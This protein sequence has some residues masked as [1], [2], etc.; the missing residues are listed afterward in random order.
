MHSWGETSAGRDP[1][2]YNGGLGLTGSFIFRGLDITACAPVLTRVRIELRR[3]PITYIMR[4]TGRPINEL[5]VG[6]TFLN[7]EDTWISHHCQ[8]QALCFQMSRLRIDPFILKSQFF[9]LIDSYIKCP[10][11]E[12]ELRAA[13][14]GPLAHLSMNVCLDH[15]PR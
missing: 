7:L 5:T 4:G 14:G 9:S 2:A 11:L 8:H 1:R 15:R 3:E 13:L 12:Y 10:H 6:G